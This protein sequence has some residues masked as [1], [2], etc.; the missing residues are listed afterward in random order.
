MF[1]LIAVISLLV[2]CTTTT[3]SDEIAEGLALKS[4]GM[5]GYIL[6]SEH[7][8]SASYYGAQ[9]QHVFVG[10]TGEGE[11]VYIRIEKEEIAKRERIVQSTNVVK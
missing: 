9:R 11:L 5:G 4:L 2:G 3:K 1:L 8:T 6:F 10:K 7:N